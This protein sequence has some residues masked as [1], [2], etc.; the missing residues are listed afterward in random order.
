M[1]LTVD[2]SG[3]QYALW[4]LHA[5]VGNGVSCPGIVTGG[6]FNP[7]FKTH[8]AKGVAFKQSLRATLNQFA[9]TLKVEVT[10]DTKP[11]ILNALRGSGNLPYLKLQGGAPQ[12]GWLHDNA[13]IHSLKLSFGS[14]DAVLEAQ[15]EFYSLIC[16]PQTA[17]I[18]QTAITG[19][20]YTALDC[21]MTIGG[22]SFGVQAFDAE[23]MNNLKTGSTAGDGKTSGHL[24]DP[25]WIVEGAEEHKIEVTTLMPFSDTPIADYPAKGIGLIG[26]FTDN[27]ANTLVMTYSGLTHDEEFSDQEFVVDGEV[28]YKNTLIGIPACLVIS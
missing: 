3:G 7:K 10:K 14:M 24:R 5:A 22:S 28:M 1:A 11:L 2:S 12:Q 4:D 17:A 9:P 13:K 25:N 15:F 16:N 23:I 6:R 20:T 21:A 19:D 27:S 18:V 26:T 8:R